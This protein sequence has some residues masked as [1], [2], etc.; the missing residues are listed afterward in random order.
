MSLALENAK[1][2]GGGSD[3]QF[4]CISSLILL[5]HPSV[6]KMIHEITGAD[7]AKIQETTENGMSV[8][9][10]GTPHNLTEISLKQYVVSL[11]KEFD[12]DTLSSKIINGKL[13]A[14]IVDIVRVGAPMPRHVGFPAEPKPTPYE[15]P[16]DTS[17][18]S[19]PKVQHGKVYEIKKKDSKANEKSPGKYQIIKDSQ[20]TQFADVS[21]PKDG[22]P[23]HY[24]TYGPEQ[25]IH[26]T[27]K[28]HIAK[29]VTNDL[30]ATRKQ[31]IS[32]IRKLQAKMELETDIDKK[33]ELNQEIRVKMEELREL[34]NADY[35]M[36]S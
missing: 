27:M 16:R 7:I 21:L 24:R 15:P 3:S 13:H 28:A 23:T 26:S 20:G 25:V 22:V 1:L 9:Q 12:I 14:S 6:L 2:T 32:D 17:V 8:W 33:N 36:K 10:K 5:T 30:T 4:Q 34:I 29:H 35:K 31:L 19:S 11:T 18:V